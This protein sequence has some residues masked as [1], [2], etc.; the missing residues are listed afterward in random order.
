MG[1]ANPCPTIGRSGADIDCRLE[2]GKEG[3]RFKGIRIGVSRSYLGSAALGFGIHQG[4]ESPAT[5]L[6]FFDRG[7]RRP[8]RQ[9]SGPI[10]ESFKEGGVEPLYGI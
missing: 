10:E 8:G 4:V 1:G 3:N 7:E 5:G 2:A 6:C 9:Y